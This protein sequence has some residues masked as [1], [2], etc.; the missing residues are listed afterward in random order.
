MAT[1]IER[2][3]LVSNDL[4]RAAAGP[5]VRYRQGYL[6]IA[7]AAT[8]RVRCGEGRAT[9]TVKGPRRGLAREEFTYPIPT[10]D[11]ARMLRQLC[12]GRVVEKVRHIVEHEGATWCVDVY[13][14][15]AEGLVVAEIELDRYDQPV[16]APPWLGPEISGDMRFSNSAIALWRDVSPGKAALPIQ[17]AAE[18]APQ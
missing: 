3:Y 11:A 9:L 4:W 15:A 1:E 8:V 5:G 10:V 12:R 17:Q 6:A 2:K 13:E 7:G 14:G 16:L 18:I